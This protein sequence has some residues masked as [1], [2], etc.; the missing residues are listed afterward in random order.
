[1]VRGRASVHATLPPAAGLA[2]ALGGGEKGT[3]LVGDLSLPLP[4]GPFLYAPPQ[5]LSYWDTRTEFTMVGPPEREQKAC[6]GMRQDWGV[7]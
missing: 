5:G 1:M 7:A 3:L 2:G 6:V 4:R